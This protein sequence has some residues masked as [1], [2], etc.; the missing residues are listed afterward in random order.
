MFS[1]TKKKKNSSINIFYGLYTALTCGLFVLF[2]P[3]IFIYA[4]IA[5]RHNS[6]IKERWGFVPLKSIQALSGSPRI[7]IHA[8]SLGEVKVAASIIEALRHIM[9]R[10]SLILST[11]TEHGRNLAQKTFREEIP[12]IYAPVDFIGSVRKA[13]ASV[14]PEL[15]VF[16]E[17]EIWPA[18]IFEAHGMGIK[19][20]LVNGRISNRSIGRY[21]R[22]RPFF[23]E[24]LGNFD[25][26]SMVTEEDAARIESMGADR[27]R[28]QVHGNAKYDL[29][30]HHVNPAIE[31]EMRQIFNLKSAAR[32]F[33]AGSTRDGEEEMVLDA[34]ENILKEF[35]D[36]ILII[37]PRHID[38]TPVIGS[39][40]ER[41]GFRYQ[42][43]SGFQPGKIKRTAQVVIL[44][45]F[46]ELFNVYSVATIVFC[47][48]SLVPLGGQNPLEPAVWGKVVFY[49]PFMENFLDAKGLLETRQAGVQVSDKEV[50]AKK[51]S[52]F[53]GHEEELKT[54]GERAREVVLNNQK[55][56]DK[57]AKVIEQV[58]KANV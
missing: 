14:R 33:V 25:V 47:G 8:A 36:T 12:V 17:T 57:H 2:S 26:F 35:P 3:A 48:G 27:G 1:L 20:A 50:L 28:I 56:S 23:R 39:L 4:F 43:R 51:A 29:L 53:L 24:V 34:Y 45:T 44:D 9:P 19:I 18:W 32:V 7:W 21:L 58:W 30:M 54:Y 11:I 55:A 46:G 22:L 37:V 41:H 13:L 40:I 10:C 31:K 16:L 52:W 42:L 15:I 6:H 49:G 38:R 5:K